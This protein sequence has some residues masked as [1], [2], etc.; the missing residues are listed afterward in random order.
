MDFARQQANDLDFVDPDQDGDV[1]D[2]VIPNL[3]EYQ[4]SLNMIRDLKIMQLDADSKLEKQELKNSLD[5][6]K[7]FLNNQVKA[8]KLTKD[9]QDK[10]ITFF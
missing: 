6:Y 3:D 10:L 2:I 7:T 8:G 5:D 9:E 1:N 4:R